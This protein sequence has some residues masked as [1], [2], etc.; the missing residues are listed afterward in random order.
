MNPPVTPLLQMR[1]IAMSFG[2]VR[3]LEGVDFDVRAGEVHALAGENGAGKSTL[4]HLL[5][6]VHRPVAGRI[7][8]AGREDVKF[9]D[10][11]AAQEA[12]VATVFQERSLFSHL[13]V[14]ENVFAGHA[15]RGRWGRIDHARLRAQTQ[16]LLDEIGLP[17]RPD[18]R[19]E[20]LSPDQQQMVE[21]AKALS[22][23]VK[24]II[25]DEPTAAL[26]E[27]ETA[28][29]FRVI[30]MLRGRGVGVIYISH[31]M[32]EIFELAD[33]VTVLKDGRREGTREVRA[34]TP[35]ELVRLMIG[36]DLPPRS[37]RSR[38]EVHG[39]TPVLELRGLA[40]APGSERERTRLRGVSLQLHAGEIV[41]LAGLAGAGRTETALSLIGARERGAGEVLV[42]GRS[43]EIASPADAIRLGIGYLHEDRKAAGIFAA[44]EIV[45]NVAVAGLR[46]FGLWRQD[47]AA[48]LEFADAKRTELKIVSR[49]LR[50]PISELSGGN[51]QKCLLAR[52]L[53][54][55]PRILIVDEPTRGV[56]VGA[57][58]EVHALLRALAAQGTAVLVISSELPE[59]LAVSDRILVMRQGAIV[60]EL[61]GEAAT[62][63]DVMRLASLD[64][65]S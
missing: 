45:E 48:Q 32:E 49:D 6:G 31:R 60:G 55:R 37:P 11:R 20:E 5:A 34:T 65:V 39:P 51:Q 24:L 28:A 2:P 46:R 18:A 7:D 57:K 56:D 12:G 4:M 44:M 58:S 50:Q 1:A 54:L 43:V 23:E 35:G 14:A 21:I 3:V 17:V 22:L 40:D 26:T 29:L 61:P 33:R 52:W 47:R 63:E 38:V 9:A 59:V 64:S 27:Q 13:T 41:G 8:F 62:E 53:L 10:P 15:P 25:F 19:V 30:R 42:D 36:R 16:R